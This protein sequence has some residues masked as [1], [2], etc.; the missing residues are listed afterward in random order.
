MKVRFFP[1]IAGFLLTLISTALPAV[2]HP[3]GKFSID[4]YSRLRVTPQALRLRY[5]IDMA[6]IPSF[7]ELQQADTDGDGDVSAV[8]RRVY[9]EQKARD[10]AARVSATLNGQPLD[11][12]IEYSNLTGPSSGGPPAAD[13]VPPTFRIFMDMRAEFPAPLS[14]RNTVR[15][16]D[17]NYPER[18]GWKEIVV[19]AEPEVRLLS[20]SAPNKDL[21][22]ELTRYPPEW[23]APPQDVVAV[24]TFELGSQGGVMSMI[25][26]MQLD[27]WLL[28]VVAA[29]GLLVRWR[30]GRKRERTFNS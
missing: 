11:W 19:E 14:E 15:Y 28:V 7:Q 20:S 22:N 13:P 9:L 4:H 6:E 26:R 27:L 29:L 12:R 25:R 2:S 30:A 5:V 1:L 10:L 8:E 21:T 24:F 23:P 17:K 3:L 16:E 18:T